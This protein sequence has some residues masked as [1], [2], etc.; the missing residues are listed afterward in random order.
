MEQF[1]LKWNKFINCKFK[2]KEHGCVVII[3]L[4][5]KYLLKCF[6]FLKG[7]TSKMELVLNINFGMF[8]L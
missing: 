4:D 5:K 1:L 2:G 6:I 8:I 7:N 3:I